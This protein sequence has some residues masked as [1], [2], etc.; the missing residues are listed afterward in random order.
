MIVKFFRGGRTRAGARSAVNYLLNERVQEGTARVYKGDPNLTLKIINSIQRKWKF[1]SGVISFEEPYKQISSLLPEIVK[2]FER[3]FFAGLNEDQYNVLYVL[4]TDKGRTELHFL[5]P[6]AELTTG[7]DLAVYTHA[8]DLKKKDI[9]Q[10]YINTKYGLSNPLN[11]EKKESLELTKKWKTDRT[12]FKK[13]LHE[14]ITEAIGKGLISSRDDIVNLLKESGIKILRVTKTSIT[15]LHPDTNKRIRLKGD[16][17]EENFGNITDFETKH[18]ER[19]RIYQETLSAG[20]GE[21]KK[22][23]D[24]RVA[25]DAETNLKKYRTTEQQSIEKNRTRSGE[26]RL[27]TGTMQNKKEMDLGDRGNVSRNYRNT[28]DTKMDDNKLSSKLRRENNGNSI[29]LEVANTKKI[30]E[31]E[32]VKRAIARVRETRATIQSITENSTNA[33]RGIKTRE[34]RIT[35]EDRR[36]DWGDYTHK[37]IIGY[38]QQKLSYID[39][40]I[41]RAYQ[42]LERLINQKRTKMDA[43][44]ERFKTEINL[45]DYLQ[46]LGYELD[47]S[48]SSR[49]SAVLKSGGEVLVVSRN[50]NGHYVYFNAQDNKDGGTIIDF[51]QRRTG[52]N[53]GQVRKDL[54]A[55]LSGYSPSEH[56][57][58]TNQFD[59]R[60]M[61]QKAEYFTRAW[62]NL[63]EL[64]DIWELFDN[65]RGINRKTIKNNE[66]IKKDKDG[67]LYFAVQTENGITGLYQT[68]N[69]MQQKFFAKG[70][71]KGIWANKKLS[72]DIKRIIVTETPTDSL[73]IQE[74]NRIGAVEYDENETLHIA[75]LGRMGEDAKK[76]LEKV[77]RMLP[78]AKIVIATDND[79]A[80]EEIASEVLKIANRENVNRITFGESKDAN[81]YLQKIR[82]EQELHNAKKSTLKIKR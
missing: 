71:I 77:F 16:F 7:K 62:E 12:E 65:I 70:S 51:I 42:Q 75:T 13:Q 32:N 64:D 30:E 59:V 50:S 61:Y 26:Y 2:E 33:N 1:T 22:R 11:P 3:T 63:D 43:E 39:K 34:Q 27:G 10:K 48:K 78:N 53:L 25:R 60:E 17:Y 40:L 15:I 72:K 35:T 76:T 66:F 44:L 41:D 69:R 82:R 56:L 80:G 68:D 19:E 6:R 21:L 45:I 49:K 24:E 55:Y 9:F 29:Q 67:N 79:I 81:E 52:K 31:D 74:L 36:V 20:V 14:I 57:T 8:K 28:I 46:D 5:I 58:P 18:R 23:L 4:H 54:R 73:S 38:I 37:Q 47:K